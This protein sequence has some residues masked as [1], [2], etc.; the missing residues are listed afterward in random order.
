MSTDR[1]VTHVHGLTTP[2][3]NK[4]MQ[5]SAGRAVH[6]V[7]GVPLPRPLIG[8][9]RPCYC[10]TDL[11]EVE[12]N[13]KLFRRR[14]MGQRKKKDVLERILDKIDRTTGC[15][16]IWTGSPRKGEYGTITID[17]K[18]RTVHRV[19]YEIFFGPIDEGMVICHECDT[20]KCCNPVHLFEGTRKE[21]NID[22]IHKGRH[23]CL[24]PNKPKKLD[25]HTVLIIRY[26]YWV[27]D[28]SIQELA[29]EFGIAERYARKIVYRTARGNIYFDPQ[30]NPNWDWSDPRV[31][32]ALGPKTSYETAP[33]EPA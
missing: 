32:K 13:H 24:S 11:T 6:V 30:E 21:N 33:N 27:F 2:L 18:T 12:C 9:V 22:A 5:P 31:M 17:G 19:M 15:C 20:P 16:W 4:P 14:L 28:D 26:S 3:S 23:Y 8:S 7:I 29:E 1:F 25:D 10:S